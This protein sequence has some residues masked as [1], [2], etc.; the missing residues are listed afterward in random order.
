MEKKKKKSNKRNAVMVCDRLVM[1]KKATM[2]RLIWETKLQI[3]DLIRMGSSTQ[4]LD[5][6][7]GFLSLCNT[8]FSPAYT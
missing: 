3:P 6:I 4:P 5:E 8:V 2:E 1:N 7:P